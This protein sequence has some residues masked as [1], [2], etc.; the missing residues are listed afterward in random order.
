M[1]PS[2]PGGDVH[3]VIAHDRLLAVIVLP[4]AADAP[5]LGEALLAGGIRCAEVTLRTDDAVTAIAAMSANPGLLVGAGTVLRRDQVDRVIEAGA[6]FVVSPGFSPT[7]VAHCRDRDIVVFP[8]VATAT[9]LQGVLELG[10]DT[11][12]FFPAEQAGGV[13]MI[14]ALAA[15]F[16]T[17]RFVPTGGVNPTNLKDYLRAPGVIAVGGTWM[18]PTDALASK[19]W[20][21]VTRLARDAVSLAQAL[22]HEHG[23]G[24]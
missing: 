12:K 1:N 9:E 22:T 20:R 16:R 17:A 13:A 14:R 18:V 10:L 5:A 8:G 15:P 6:R 19:D 3:A 7:V 24:K 11:V 23:G 4:D 2:V 21:R